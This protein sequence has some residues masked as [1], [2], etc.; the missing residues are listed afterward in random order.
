MNLI[1]TLSIF[2]SKIKLKIIE[3]MLLLYVEYLV[4]IG[5]KYLQSPKQTRQLNLHSWVLV[6]SYTLI[7][8]EWQNRYKL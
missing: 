7:H 1:A 8:C 3:Q 6:F 4:H 2:W 5:T